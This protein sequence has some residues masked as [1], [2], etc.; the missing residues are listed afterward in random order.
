MLIIDPVCNLV[1]PQHIFKRFEWF[2]GVAEKMTPACAEMADPRR[3]GPI[4]H[5][6]FLA[7][8]HTQIKKGA[9]LAMWIQ[10]G[11]LDAEFSVC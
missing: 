11:F 5:T 2:F 7:V 10:F 6:V 8:T 3:L 1:G 9:V 4:I